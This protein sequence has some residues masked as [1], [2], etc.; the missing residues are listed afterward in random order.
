MKRYTDAELLDH[1][2]RLAAEL[3]HTPTGEEINAAEGPS[4]GVYQRRFGKES[5]TLAGL[6]PRAVGQKSRRSQQKVSCHG[7]GREGHSYHDC[8]NHFK[9]SGSRRRVRC[10]R[11]EQLGHSTREC[12]QKYLSKYVVGARFPKFKRERND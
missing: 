12:R 5:S 10:Q 1:L 7:C 8:P 6:V 2:R 3:G 9:V 11:C 4:T